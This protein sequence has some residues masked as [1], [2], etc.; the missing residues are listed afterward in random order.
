MEAEDWG[1]GN[2]DMEEARAKMAVVRSVYCIVVVLE[3]QIVLCCSSDVM[4][5][6]RGYLVIYI[7][8]SSGA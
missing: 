2:A 8:L 6:K 1:E 5:E 3:S 4:S 7:L